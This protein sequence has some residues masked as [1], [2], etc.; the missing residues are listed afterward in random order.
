MCESCLIFVF[1]VMSLS[2]SQPLLSWI[3][4]HPEEFQKWS[5][6][7]VKFRLLFDYKQTLGQMCDN[8]ICGWV[9]LGKY[10]SY[11]VYVRTR[12]NVKIEFLF[13][14]VVCSVVYVYINLI[15]FY[16][17]MVICVQLSHYSV[18]ALKKKTLCLF[19]CQE[20]MKPSS[21]WTISS[22]W[23]FPALHMHHFMTPACITHLYCLLTNTATLACFSP[24]WV[25]GGYSGRRVGST[26]EHHGET[27]VQCSRDLPTIASV[28]IGLLP[29]P[30]SMNSSELLQVGVMGRGICLIFMIFL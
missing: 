21:A 22:C 20:G 16:F 1:I 24:V 14:G 25:V 18:T 12:H 17:I 6:S 9:C 29:F 26:G 27:T 15:W 4:R 10:R 30:F 8:A 23:C 11:K 7:E 3:L 13:T 19:W 5:K 28:L 2:L